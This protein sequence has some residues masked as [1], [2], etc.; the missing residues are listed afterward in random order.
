MTQHKNPTVG[1]YP[2]DATSYPAGSLQ[3]FLLGF[4]GKPICSTMLRALKGCLPLKFL[5]LTSWS[6]FYFWHPQHP[7][8]RE[9]LALITPL[10][11]KHFLLFRASA[12]Q[13]QDFF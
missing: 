6:H 12:Q 2:G 4:R 1:F 11:K 3:G 9:S 10:M 13:F 7:V 8:G 5:P